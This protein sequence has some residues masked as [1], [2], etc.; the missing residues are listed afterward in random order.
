MTHA[1]HRGTGSS[2]HPPGPSRPAGQ[3]QLAAG[4]S[5]EPRGPG[6]RAGRPGRAAPWH[7]RGGSPGSDHR[8]QFGTWPRTQP[9]GGGPG[10]REGRLPY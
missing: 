3:W 5:T 2:C 9:A 1:S 10:T 6:R 7:R 4:D 8:L